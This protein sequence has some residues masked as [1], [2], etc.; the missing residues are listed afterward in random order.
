MGTLIIPCAGRS[1]RFPNM[2][3]KWLLTHPDGQLMVEKAIGAMDLSVYD[4]VVVVIVQPHIE[5]YEAKVILDQAFADKNYEV[6]V[7][8]DF[9]SCASETVNKA[10]VRSDIQGAFVVRDSDNMVKFPATKLRNFVVGLDL[11]VFPD[12]S[13]VTG[14][15]F[16]I[17]NDQNIIV[18]IIEKKVVSNI[19]SLGVYGFQSAEDFKS[20]YN[21]L[22]DLRQAGECYIS[23]VIGYMIGTGRYEFDYVPAGYFEDWGTLEDW[24]DVQKRYRTFFVDIDGIIM[25]N[26][27]KYGKTNWSNNNRALDENIDVLKNLQSRGG[28]IIFATCRT[29]EYA[30]K[31]EKILKEK[32]LTDFR[33]ITGLNHAQR[34]IINDFAPT[35]PYPSCAA[36]NIPRNGNL[37]NYLE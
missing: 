1:T 21:E 19:I 33:M 12:V 36:V 25:K 7:L 10:L 18:N 14:K 4:R 6:C 20:A 17:V 29:D 34:V 37:A 3:P 28:E 9:T 2:K 23:H 5:Q 32:G 13:N 30:L 31:V 16:L 11:N 35:N 8:D 26:S 27:G 22:G 24:K 15:S